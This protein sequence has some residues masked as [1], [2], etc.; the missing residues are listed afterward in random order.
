MDA[1]ADGSVDVSEAPQ[2]G[3]DFMGQF[4]T[5]GDKKI[6][7]DEFMA[8]FKQMDQSGDGFVEASEAPGPP[9]EAGANP[10]PPPPAN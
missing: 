9:P 6:S 8:D 7:K 10:P 1:S 3:G 5:S 4:D 2:G